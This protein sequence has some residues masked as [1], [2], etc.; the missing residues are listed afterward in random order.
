MAEH[1][2]DAALRLLSVIEERVGQLSDFPEL[3]PVWSKYP[4]TGVRCLLCGKHIV[5]YEVVPN[6]AKV[7]IL[8][9]RHGR[10]QEPELAGM[11]SG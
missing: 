2:A 8:T 9:V 4:W 5:Y 11:K 3:G 1:S 7:H 10:E 6:R